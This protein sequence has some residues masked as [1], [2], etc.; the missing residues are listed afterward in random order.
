MQSSKLNLKHGLDI[1]RIVNGGLEKDKKIFSLTILH[2]VPENLLTLLEDYVLRYYENI[3]NVA[4][5]YCAN[6]IV[7]IEH[8]KD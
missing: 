6:Y 8:K 5:P 7:K 4:K 2:K 1:E 3:K